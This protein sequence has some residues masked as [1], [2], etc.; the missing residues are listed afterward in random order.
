MHVRLIRKYS[1]A[2]N[3]VDLSHVSVGDVIC[4]PERTAL[5]LLQEGWAELFPEQSEPLSHEKPPLAP[6]I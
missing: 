3:G 6:I 2:L 5:M 4:L 1:T